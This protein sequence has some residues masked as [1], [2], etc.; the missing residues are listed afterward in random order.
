[1]RYEEP[2]M[3]CIVFQ[4][5]DV[6]TTSQELVPGTDIGIGSDLEDLF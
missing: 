2:K 1:M 4:V 5:I 6:L 3:E